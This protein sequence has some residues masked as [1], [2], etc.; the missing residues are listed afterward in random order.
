[1]FEEKVLRRTFGPTG[2]EV[3][4]GW[5]KLRNEELHN[6]Q[7]SANIIRIIMP[8]S[9]R[10][11]GHIGSMAETNSLKVLLGKPKGKRPLGR[12]MYKYKDNIKINL[13]ET[14]WVD[15]IWIQ[16]T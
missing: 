10:W 9:I 3:T 4:G 11:I 12:P 5:G 13:K 1:M 6:L 7:S 15:V 16:M 14:G 8:R 2:E